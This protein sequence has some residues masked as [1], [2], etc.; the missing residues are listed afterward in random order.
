MRLEDADVRGIVDGD[1]VTVKSRE[2]EIR[3]K[4]KITEDVKQG[5]VVVDFGWGNPGDEGENVNRLTSDDVRD[6]IA[7]STSN[8]RFL[9]EVAKAG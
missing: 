3:V 7:A 6:P 2:G 1:M 9:C 5:W 8:R 4:A